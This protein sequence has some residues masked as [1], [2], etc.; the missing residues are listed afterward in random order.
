MKHTVKVTIYLLALFF[1]AQLIGVGVLSAYIDTTA[2]DQAG[3]TVFS[4]MEVAGVEI[5]P[6]AVDETFS[7]LYIA[8][9]IL[10]GTGIVFLIMYFQAQALWKFWFFAASVLTVSIAFA[11]F[12]PSMPAFGLAF[13]IGLFRVYKPHI[14]A[15][16]ISELFTY[17]GLAAIFVPIMN[18][19]SAIALLVFISFY[20]M[21]A[22]WKSKH[23][24]A[25][26]QYQIKTKLFAGLMIP[27]DSKGVV[28]DTAKL[29]SRSSKKSN[30]LKK[31]KSKKSTKK[32]QIVN[33]AILGGGDI[34]F[35][36]FFIGTVLKFYGLLP[37]LT[38]IPFVTAALALLF[39]YSE[40]GKFYP[41]MPIVSFGCLI[42]LRI[43]WVVFAI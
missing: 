22:V 36:L 14:I 15:H 8:I 10:V 4:T 2:S 28:T 37:A 30:A 19:T 21:Y 18:L 13:I 17:A 25:M 24:V 26:A 11:A 16:N 35:P 31:T 23:M 5:E 3:K 29:G 43:A 6:P 42:G 7:F 12:I 41:A 34:G 33:T 27:Y 38:I 39:Y 40:K 1:V 9:A 32:T 20:D